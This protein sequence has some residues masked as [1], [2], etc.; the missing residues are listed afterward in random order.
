LAFLNRCEES[1]HRAIAVW[2]S[3][4]EERRVAN[5]QMKAARLGTLKTQQQQLTELNQKVESGQKALEEASARLKSLEVSLGDITTKEAERRAS[6][7][8]ANIGFNNLGQQLSD[9]DRKIEEAKAANAMK[10]AEKQSLLAEL[11]LHS[12]TLDTET[13][14]LEKALQA[15]T[16]EPQA[17][18]SSRAASPVSS[19]SSSSS[20]DSSSSDSDSDGSDSEPEV[21]AQKIVKPGPKVVIY[22]SGDESPQVPSQSAALPARLLKRKQDQGGTSSGMSSLNSK[23]SK[24]DTDERSSLGSSAPQPMARIPKKAPN[25][26]P[27]RIA[28]QALASQFFVRPDTE[29][30][31]EGR[32]ELG[33]EYN[34]L[35]L[36]DDVGMKTCLGDPTDSFFGRVDPHSEEL[37]GIPGHIV[38]CSQ[39]MRS[40][41]MRVWHVGIQG[42]CVF[43]TTDDRLCLTNRKFLPQVCRLLGLRE[44]FPFHGILILAGGNDAVNLVDKDFV[45]RWKRTRDSRVPTSFGNLTEFIVERIEYLAD[46]TKKIIGY[47][48]AGSMPALQSVKASA[49]DQVCGSAVQPFLFHL[50]TKVEERRHRQIQPGFEEEIR[51]VYLPLPIYDDEAFLK[52]RSSSDA[53]R[54]L[55]LEAYL[56]FV[57]D[58]HNRAAVYL[59]HFL[60]PET[61]TYKLFGCGGL[62]PTAK[63]D[64][65]DLLA[66]KGPQ[67][68]HLHDGVSC[69]G[70]HCVAAGLRTGLDFPLEQKVR[71]ILS[72]GVPLGFS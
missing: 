3:A 42:L 55:K 67:D 52:L 29:G 56:M 63:I 14:A 57:R 12:T 44:D 66:G 6:L 33:D 45:A 58:V 51:V 34:L 38:N 40:L 2:T 31:V 65:S 9:L 20:S 62:L 11:L 72:I 22:S 13:Q 18:V 47:L 59:S 5:T 53:R 36:T 21:L 23:K 54:T 46:S 39:S 26:G 61:Y 7:T 30:V 48:G 71:P 17:A 49:R 60:E 43:F 41:G 50:N 4:T 1:F 10:E 28:H 32:I 69:K 35:I 24:P 25:V 68:D 64:G 19:T 15:F 16:S 27:I 70:T 37:V 8:M